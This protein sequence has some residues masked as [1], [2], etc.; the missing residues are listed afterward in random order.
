LL[1]FLLWTG[2]SIAVTAQSKSATATPSAFGSA[3]F[4]ASATELATAS[5][6]VPPSHEHD[7]QILYE[8]GNYRIAADGTLA[9][10]ERMIYRIDSADGVKNWAEISS[11]WDPWFEKQVQ[12]QARVLEPN[13]SFVELDQKTI[14]DAPVHAD[15][16]EDDTYSSE[17]ERR[18]PLPGL[19]I[20]AIVEELI[21]TD[22]KQP[23][24]A[25]GLAYR[26]SFRNNMPI[27]HERMTVELPTATPFKD[28][29]LNLPDLVISRTEVDGQRRIVYEAANLPARHG[30]DIDLET[31]A[32]NTPMVEFAT[33]ASWAAV[34]TT[35]ASLSEPQAVVADVQPILPDNLPADRAAKIRAIVARLH[36]VAR[37][38]G[39][40]F[41]AAK[42]TPQ[43]PAEVI[44]RHYG[45][46][47]DKA[48]LLVTMLRAAGIPA[49]LA[50]LSTGPGR[51]VQ[52]DLPGMN[53]FDHAIVYVPAIGADGKPIIPGADETASSAKPAK[54][55][56]AGKFVNEPVQPALWIDA[57]AEYNEVGT[58]PFMDQGRLALVV[59]PE[60]KGLS[61]IPA[62]RPEDSVLIETRTFVL[63][64]MGESKVVELSETHGAVDANYRASYGGSETPRLHE[65]ME[66]YVQNAYLAKKLTSITHG[67][68]TDFEHPFRLTIAAEGVRRGYTSMDEANVALFPSGAANGLPKW[69]FQAPPVVGKD[70]SDE[71]RHDLDLASQSRQATYVIRPFISECR[72]RILIP[73]GFVLRALPPD[74]TT[75]MGTATL[76]ETYVQTEPDIV[77]ATFR[78]N[79]GPT[80]LT[81]EQALALRSAVLELNKRDWVGIYLD[82]VGAKALANGH[83]REALEA[84][85]A[86]IAAQPAEA[87]HHVRLARALLSAGIGDEA[88]DEARHATELDPKSAHAFSTLGWTLEHN[89][90]GVRFG[91]G[92]DL[93]GSIAAYRKAIELDS[94]DN[95]TRFNL[96]IL[97]EFNPRG[98]R[99]A[100]D[101][102]LTR[103]IAGYSELIERTKDKEPQSANSYRDNMVY[104][105]LFSRQFAELDKL[106]AD[107]PST[108]AHT[109]CAI[110][111][112]AAQHGAEAGIARAAQG[113]ASASDRNKNLRQA[114]MYLATLRLYAEAA[115]VASAGIQG[116]D[117]APAVARQIELYRSLRSSNLDP[118]PAT[119][120]ASPVKTILYN[121]MAGTLTHEMTAAALSRRAYSSG[122]SMERDIQRNLASSGFLRAIADKSEYTEPVLLD[123]L[124]GNMTYTSTGDDATGY[125][126]VAQTPGDEPK[127]F[128][129]LREDGTYRVVAGDYDRVQLGIAV[130]YA[131]DHNS[132]AQAKAMLD[133]K[134]DL[135]PRESG[136]DPFDGPLLPRFWTIGSSKPGADSPAAMRIAAIS[137]LAG[138][139]DAKPYLDELASA[140]EKAS[141]ARQTDLDLLLAEA[142]NGAEQPVIALTSARRLLDQEPDSLTALRLTGE[143]LLL[144]GDAAG[145][146][147]L[148]APLLARKPK[149]HDLLSQQARA[150]A[151]VNDF[152]AAQS[153]EQKVLDSG[154]ADSGDYNGYAWFGLFHGTIGDDIIKAAQQANMLTKNGSFAELHTLACVYAAAGRTTEARQVLDQAMYAGNMSQPD[155]EVWYALGL[156]YEQ[157]GAKSA[158]LAAFHRVQAHELDD[159]TYIDPESTYVLAQ[160]R[161]KSLTNSISK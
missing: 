86:L 126:V 58:L 124:A 23:Y 27:A 136:D 105:L 11:Q 35:Y 137:L 131:L 125:S 46:C 153:T 57:T 104:A 142:A 75:P 84:D 94:D 71:M 24:F 29:V 1:I 19:A 92:Y 49:N 31:D 100:P 145:W 112:A 6:E 9:F 50:L 25:G 115:D 44:Q 143:S 158:A 114:G 101:S 63:S 90:L 43:R 138:S 102:D 141:G 160:A 4:A 123:L 122:E 73:E 47:K 65:N 10:R 59:S 76:T 149:D 95:D 88:H 108:N 51:D 121:T 132:P 39:V 5:A 110:A 103:A 99:Y 72:T 82:Q 130:L 83:I 77:T 62:A 118:L 54:S 150:Y 161:I 87:L 61:R 7:V 78:F 155:S 66:N 40:E 48:T 139:M 144:T 3:P 116:G 18:A 21:S 98:I 159:H 16:D 152:V 42:L 127:H 45:D 157:Y 41:G 151:M 129:V 117:D 74:K 85:R 32:P 14:T 107:L 128:Y 119:N 69:F 33:G 79:S 55:I 147:K 146:Q 22:E 96:A 36:Q 30:S 28:L 20:G 2:A 34:A 68:G 81:A 140:R 89:D 135:T 13:G 148:L 67:D 64:E 80:T 120:P 134:R 60:T 156:I 12:L 56:K 133:W 93:A 26:Y 15:S 8:E 111:S 109:A 37:Y 154:K 91:K 97:Y 53:H 52:P 70:T 17:H 113:N 38:T 106:L